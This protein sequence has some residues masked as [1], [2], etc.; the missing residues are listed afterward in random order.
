MLKYILSFL[1]FQVVAYPVIAQKME[2]KQELQ[3]TD[4]DSYNSSPRDFEQMLIRADST[5]LQARKL[6]LPRAELSGLG[7]K[8]RYFAGV[9]DFTN[10]LKTAQILFEKATEYNNPRYQAIAKKFRSDAFLSMNLFDEALKELDE[11]LNLINRITQPNSAI[12]RA[13][14][15]LWAGYANYYMRQEDYKNKLKYI[16]LAGEEYNKI[17]DPDQRQRLLYIHYSNLAGVFDELDQPDSASYYALFSEALASK[18]FCSNTIRQ[19]NLAVLG[20][21]SMKTEDYTAALQY[22]KEAEKL[23]ARHN[24]LNILQIY[25]LVIESYHAMGRE[26]SALVYVAK[27]DSL[28]LAVSENQNQSL[29]YLFRNQED[30]AIQNPA[31]YLIAAVVILLTLFGFY[32]IRKRRKLLSDPYKEYNLAARNTNAE[33]IPESDY[34]KLSEMLKH[35]DPLFLTYFDEVFPEFSTTLSE[36]TPEISTTDLEFCAI[37]KLKIPTKDI[38]RY[39][40]I[41]PKTVQNRKY[42]I[43]K[44][45]NIPPE[46]DTY[47]WFDAY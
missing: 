40:H 23:E 39:R 21:A 14:A 16:K 29:R 34:S 46:V 3:Y 9:Y 4:S 2:A 7:D 11:G 44:K 20:S 25:N 35:N 47:K 43:R 27:R 13:K 31:V 19:I 24:Y 22:F 1:L 18:E 36:I 15:D 33:R 38:A 41:S 37:L 42:L 17:T 45:L 10:L 6:N 8:C 28:K 26:D 32:V 5:I 12:I 30:K